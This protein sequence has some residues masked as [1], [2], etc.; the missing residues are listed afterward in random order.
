MFELAS[1][2]LARLDGAPAAA[3]ARLAVVTVTHVLGSAPRALGSSMA[4]DRE[5]RVI[6]SISGGCVEAQAYALAEELLATGL[7]ATDHFGFDDDAAFAAG[8]TCGGQLRVFG[9]TVT[10]ADA[11]V[12][13]QLRAAASGRSAGL[14]LVIAG[15]DGQRGRV[16]TDSGVPPTDTA[17]RRILA[18]L[19]ARIAT[20]VSST[21]EAECDGE[22]LEVLH[23]VHA[24]PPR[25]IV[26]GA[27]DFS[28][29]LSDAAALRGYR[30][31]VCDAR[32]VFATPER[33]PGADEVVVAWPHR[34]LAAEAEAGRL[35]GRTALA[36]LTH[37][38]KFD[39]PVLST[40][41]ALARDGRVGYVGA[42]GSRSTHDRRLALLQEAGVPVDAIELLHSP[43]GLDLGASTPQE[44]A[45]SIVAEIVRARNGASGRPLAGRTGPI[46]A[47]R[48]ASAWVLEETPEVV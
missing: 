34:Y 4:V 47:D 19:R 20:G 35:D 29:A 31:T 16:I 25:L 17:G 24:T 40:A 21:T 5:G 1:E 43:I 9:T 23:L 33:F 42:M 8:L 7:T 2:L 37:D 48:P 13:E 26:F 6:G 27:V 41:L 46:H 3:P 22:T 15:P 10:A 32:P 36:V 39:V 44:T 28:A 11:A 45:V 30:V 12:V 18:D 14:A 38:E